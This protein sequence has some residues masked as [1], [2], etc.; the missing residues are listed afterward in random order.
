VSCVSAK[1]SDICETSEKLQMVAC[2]SFY[3]KTVTQ[4]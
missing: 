3:L 4:L 1:R 2:N